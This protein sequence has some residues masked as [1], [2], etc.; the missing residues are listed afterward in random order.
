MTS[1]QVKFDVVSSRN[2]EDL[3][4]LIETISSH[5]QLIH[6]DLVDFNKAIY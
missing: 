5:Y 6:L 2:L 3:Q 1:M 4:S